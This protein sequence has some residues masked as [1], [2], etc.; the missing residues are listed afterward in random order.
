MN[1]DVRYRLHW[2]GRN[3]RG[4]T[5]RR[6]TAVDMA[7]AGN[8][9]ECQQVADDLEARARRMGFALRYWIAESA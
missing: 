7:G 6:G 4:V 8:R 1:H 3:R 2:T 5:P 9:F